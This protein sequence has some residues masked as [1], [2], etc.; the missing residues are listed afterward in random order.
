MGSDTRAMKEI[1]TVV[2]VRDRRG[3][4]LGGRRGRGSGSE[5]VGDGEA[6]VGC[7]SC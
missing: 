2:G 1:V 4:Y 3:G 5:A 7:V 6:A